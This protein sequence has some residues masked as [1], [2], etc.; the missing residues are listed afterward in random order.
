MK[1]LFFN[2]KFTFSRHDTYRGISEF[3]KKNTVTKIYFFQS[4]PP[5]EKNVVLLLKNIDYG[6]QLRSKNYIWLLTTPRPSPQQLWLPSV[7]K[8]ITK[9]PGLSFVLLCV[10][11]HPVSLV[12]VAC[13]YKTDWYILYHCET[14]EPYDTNQDA[15]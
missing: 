9:L 3:R 11:R 1:L 6:I 2:M 15:L 13:L 10:H 7:K 14:Y 5:T 8:E 12:S 4:D